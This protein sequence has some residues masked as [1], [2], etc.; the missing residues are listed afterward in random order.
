MLGE[1]GEGTTVVLEVV[2]DD[3]IVWNEPLCGRGE[4]GQKALRV[5]Y[6]LQ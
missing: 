4:V 1:Y 6:L 3:P 5:E 2:D